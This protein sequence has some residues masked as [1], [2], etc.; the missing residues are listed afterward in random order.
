[1]KYSS[2]G[3]Y[4]LDQRPS[5]AELTKHVNVSTKWRQ[6]GI[7][8]ELDTQRLDAIEANYHGDTDTKLSKMYEEWLN[9]TPNATRRQLLEVL[10]RSS[11]NELYIAYK[12]ERFCSQLSE[13]K[14][15][16]TYR[17]VYYCMAL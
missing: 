3:S 5:V 1:M 8:L 12:Y 13:G 9:S 17:S 6:V 7:Q 14:L 15:Y 11:I 10:R 2:N 4:Y 16:K